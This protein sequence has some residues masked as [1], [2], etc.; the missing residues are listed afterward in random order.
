MLRCG[1]AEVDITPPLGSS[2]PGYFK[3]RRSSGVRDPLYAKALVVETEERTVAFIVTDTIDLARRDVERIRERVQQLTDIPD[4]HIMVSA[5]HTHTGP[6]V[7]EGFNSQID[8]SYM[9]WFAKKAADAAVLAHKGRVEAR[10]GFGRGHEAD[11]A[12]NR[13]YFMKDGTFRTNPGVNNPLTDRAAGP[14]DPELLVVRIDAADGSPIGVLTNYACHTDA[15]G[16]SEYSA[17]FPGVMSALIKKALGDKT[18]HMFMMG[19]SGNINHIDISGK[20]KGPNHHIRIG[21]VL[22]AETLK[23]R[24]K[25]VDASG[26]L[27]LDVNR[28][29]FGAP[30]RSPTEQEVR[31]A[32]EALGNEAAAGDVELAFARQIRKLQAEGPGMTEIEI[33][34]IRLGGLAIVGVPAE[35]F[36]E[37]GLGIKANSPFPFT[38]V[39]ELCNGS[40][41]G[42]ICTQ[43]A[44]GQGGYEPRTSNNSKMAI[45]TGDRI[46]EHVVELLHSLHSR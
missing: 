19:T 5:T 9:E 46:V 35:L 16:G 25:I 27:E 13:R 3:D 38:L 21:T 39:N 34:S 37:F 31:Q 8:E 15:V 17:D 44:Y 41:R 20:F 6:P 1:M 23:V 28:T 18:I 10:I 22:A 42:Y 7:K 45:D 4:S 33:Q 29:F 36:V 43:E 26:E 2:I 11:I 32:D 30:H 40:T 12:F 14:I 24:E